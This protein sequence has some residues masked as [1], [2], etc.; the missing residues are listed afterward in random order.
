MSPQC[1][2]PSVRVISISNESIDMWF[3]RNKSHYIS[4]SKL[5]VSTDVHF[6]FV[7]VFCMSNVKNFVKNAPW[8]WGHYFQYKKTSEQSQYLCLPSKT[9]VSALKKCC[10][11]HLKKPLHLHLVNGSFKRICCQVQ[12]RHTGI[13]GKSTTRNWHWIDPCITSKGSKTTYIVIVNSSP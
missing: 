2:L 11:L 1:H 9:V 8:Q 6:I 10:G 3:F 13:D 7:Q 4:N 5:C 12:Y